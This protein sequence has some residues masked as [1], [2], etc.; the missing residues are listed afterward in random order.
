ML[1]APDATITLV[2]AFR[3][4][5]DALGKI[6]EGFRNIKFPTIA[7]P[8]SSWTRERPVDRARRLRLERW[9]RRRVRREHR[10]ARR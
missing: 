6:V 2:A 8:R 3:H 10:K 1:A 7:L 5:G 4:M 9:A